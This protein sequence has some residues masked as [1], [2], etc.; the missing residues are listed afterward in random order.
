M[1]YNFM[2]YVQGKV[3]G[4]VEANS[5][6]EAK[7][8]VEERLRINP[9]IIEDDDSKTECDIKWEIHEEC[10]GNVCYFCGG[11]ISLEALDE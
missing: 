3:Y 2:A 1:E 7:Q 8:K 6:E 11:G 5:E 4:I 10:H 9:E